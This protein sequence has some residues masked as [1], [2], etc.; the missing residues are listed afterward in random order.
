[1]E[2]NTAVDVRYAVHPNDY[3]NYDMRQLREHFLVKSLFV[4][5]ELKL[6]Y[7][8]YDRFIVGGVMPVGG[9]VKL[10]PVEQIKGEYFLERRELGVI[11]IGGTGKVEV[12]GEVFELGT[13]DALY[14]GRGNRD[15]SFISEDPNKPAKFYINSS[16]AHE[17]CPNRKV[18]LADADVIHIGD[19][20]TCNERSI[21]KL[22][23]HSVV[24]TCQLQMG[25]TEFKPGSCWNTM[26]AHTHDRRMEAYFYFDFP[27]DQAVC[28]FMGPKTETRHLWLQPEQ[29]VVSPPWSIHSGVGTASYTFIWGMAGENLDYDDMDKIY[30]HEFAEEA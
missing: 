3:K 17:R 19:P 13:R 10:P 28:H 18:N 20:S 9:V 11:N 23:V 16:P 27:E 29:A 26:P 21:N 7:S 15:V 6:T 8:H 4:A 1:M 5:N 24:K 22:L 14:L 30:P 12:D 25:L 2:T